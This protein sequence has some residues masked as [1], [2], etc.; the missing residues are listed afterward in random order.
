MHS[1]LLCIITLITII[2][3]K[4]ELVSISNIYIYIYIYI[5]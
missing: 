5:Y 3:C 4:N 1:L 2:E